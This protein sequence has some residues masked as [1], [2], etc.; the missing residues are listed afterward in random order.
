[1][2]LEGAVGP[3]GLPQGARP[4]GLRGAGLRPRGASLASLG[5][6]RPGGVRRS[7]A[8]RRARDPGLKSAAAGEEIPLSVLYRPLGS[9]A[10]QDPEGPERSSAPR[11]AP[12]PQSQPAREALLS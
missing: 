11:L 2:Q 8:P 12:A 9:A 7:G 6:T 4:L 5:P 1:M 10:R 3:R